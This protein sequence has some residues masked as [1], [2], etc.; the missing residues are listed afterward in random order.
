MAWSEK[1]GGR[2][3]T[4]YRYASELLDAMIQDL[5]KMVFTEANNWGITD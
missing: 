2:N 4:R 3:N 5:T 1:S